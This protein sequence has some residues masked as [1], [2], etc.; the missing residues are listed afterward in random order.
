MIFSLISFSQ[1]RYMY[2]NLRL[3]RPDFPAYLIAN[4]SDTVGIVFTVENVQKI[5][6]NLEVLE[7]LEK[8]QQTLDT[9]Q[10]YTA[11]LVDNLEQKIDYQKYQIINLI[12][13]SLMKDGLITNLRDQL[14]EK[15][16]IIA[17]NDTIQENNKLII[18]EKDKEI[19][20]QKTIKWVS[21]LA[22]SAIIIT[23]IILSI[24][25]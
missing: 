2:Q 1:E 24:S 11:S 16:L 3:D 5:D 21:I 22:G 15:N 14:K 6:R 23:L 8:N 18:K 20:K 9:V 13:Q 12:S 25:K 4:E 19:K 17:R 7:Y 10:Y